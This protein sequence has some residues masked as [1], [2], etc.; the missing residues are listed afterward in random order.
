MHASLL[1]LT[2]EPW[3][4]F[5]GEGWTPRS[6][7]EVFHPKVIWRHMEVSTSEKGV[8]PGLFLDRTDH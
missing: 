6:R 4:C 8:D 1:P 7:T 5:K 3:R 2:L